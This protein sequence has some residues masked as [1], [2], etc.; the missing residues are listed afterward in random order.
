MH[1]AGTREAKVIAI[2]TKK[3]PGASR[4]RSLFQIELPRGSA[5][6]QDAHS[7]NPAEPGEGLGPRRV[8]CIDGLS[9]SRPTLPH[10]PA[11]SHEV[12]CFEEAQQTRLKALLNRQARIFPENAGVCPVYPVSVSCWA[13]FCEQIAGKEASGHGP[14]PARWRH[15][16]MSLGR[17]WLSR[18]LQST[19]D[20][21]W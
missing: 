12:K 20:G 3:A 4:C 7:F 21:I 5:E 19:C 9:Y 10:A 6:S 18:A 15:C 11:R 8:G 17:N 16:R 1:C 14:S 2:G 13:P